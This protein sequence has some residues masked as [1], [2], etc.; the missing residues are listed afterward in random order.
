MGIVRQAM[1][2]VGADA[3]PAEIDG[4][5]KA[6]HG[7]EIPYGVISAYKSAIN[8]KSGGGKRGRGRSSDEQVGV[9]DVVAVRELI[10]RYGADEL[11]R[12][13]KVLG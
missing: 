4:Y 7:V 6:K 12:L 8:A 11:V 9:M 13:I 5:V 10:G 3:K 2:E 1:A